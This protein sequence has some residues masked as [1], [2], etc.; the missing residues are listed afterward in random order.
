MDI[1]IRAVV[2]FVFLL[3]LTRVIGRR[4][5]S[6][7]A[8]FDL[9][10]LIIVGDAVQQGL[11]QDDY[12]MTGAIIA[13]GTIAVLQV[14]VSYGSFRLPPLRNLLEGHPIVI[15]QDGKPIWKNMRRERLTLEEL[16]EE[17]R[18]QQVSS[19]DDVRWAVLE[20]SGNISF[21]PKQS[22]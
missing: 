14:L 16:M 11:T 1:A 18:Q 22:S 21:I 9:I 2:I 5:L 13:V 6:T 17:A 10:L 15:V 12:S 4:E 3:I 8:P 7:L 20:P 19:L